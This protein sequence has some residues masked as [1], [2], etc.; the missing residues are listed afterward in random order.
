M[1]LPRI[2][3]NA[4]RINIDKARKRETPPPPPSSF[5]EVV[6]GGAKLLLSGAQA[7]TSVVGLPAL[8]AAISGARSSVDNA[9]SGSASSSKDATDPMKNMLD[10][11][12]S[13]DLKLLA[14]QSQIQRHNRQISMV[15]NVMKARHDTAKAAIGNMRS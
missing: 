3:R 14:L 5:K 8:S 11:R 1:S 12:M 9:K 10:Q 2:G 4:T 15:S 13:D 7:A 6:K